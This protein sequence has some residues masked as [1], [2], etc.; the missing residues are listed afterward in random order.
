[1]VW[2]EE[3]LEAPQAAASPSEERA[4]RPAD[5]TAD[6][7]KE[8][9]RSAVLDVDALYR[10]YRRHV[11]ATVINI[12]GP[13]ADVEDLVHQV[14]VGVLRGQGSFRGDCS[15]KTWV[16]RIAVRTALQEIRRRR[17][18]RWLRLLNEPE[19]LELWADGADLGAQL[20]SRDALRALDGALRRIS[21]KKR[22]A[23]V[24][25]DVQGL[26]LIEA[27]DVLEVP[28]NTVRSRL[29]AARRELVSDPK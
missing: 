13:G 23:F 14:F 11:A 21:T 3:P 26:S 5:A 24:L 2:S 9:A 25:V 4:R 28:L 12:V 16:Y 8:S 7:P 19:A 18:K 29:G 6:S 1:M 15:P 27:A 20:E 10:T 22:A 17:R